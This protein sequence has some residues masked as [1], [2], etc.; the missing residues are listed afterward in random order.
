MMYSSIQR[1]ISTWPHLLLSGHSQNSGV[2]NGHELLCCA[3]LTLSWSLLI[4]IRHWVIFKRPGKPKENSN[5]SIDKQR[6]VMEVRTIN[7]HALLQ[8]LANKYW[9]LH[10]PNIQVQIEW[11]YQL[12]CPNSKAVLQKHLKTVSNTVTRHSRSVIKL[13]FMV[14]NLKCYGAHD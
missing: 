3:Y 6:E 2:N 11:Q 14:E 5:T 10:N 9:K 8:F 1:N 7:M 13:Q 4:L 12:P